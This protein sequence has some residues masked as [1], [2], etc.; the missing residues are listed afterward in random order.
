MVEAVVAVVAAVEETATVSRR[1]VETA[2]ADAEVAA[3]RVQEAGAS[4][5]LAWAWDGTRAAEARG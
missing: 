3:A 5:G 4:R 1:A 2:V